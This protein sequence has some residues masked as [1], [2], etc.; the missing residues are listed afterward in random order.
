M[1]VGSVMSH[2][3]EGEMI[4]SSSLQTKQKEGGLYSPTCPNLTFQPFEFWYAVTGHLFLFLEETGSTLCMIVISLKWCRGPLSTV[5]I[6]SILF[7]FFDTKRCWSYAICFIKTFCGPSSS[8]F[9]FLGK[10]SYKR[11]WTMEDLISLYS[12]CDSDFRHLFIERRLVHVNLQ[13]CIFFN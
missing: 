4:W 12:C 1:V 5:T 11:I 3:T 6:T 10:S 2:A 8:F 9:H 7:S 13:F